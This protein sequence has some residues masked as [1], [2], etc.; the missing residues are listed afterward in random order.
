[1][2]EATITSETVPCG[3]HTMG[4][5][6]TERGWLTSYPCGGTCVVVSRTD[7]MVHYKC[8]SC[9]FHTARRSDGSPLRAWDGL[10]K[11]GT[12][13]EGSGVDEHDWRI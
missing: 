6:R 11:D 1:M 4:E 8:Q 10:L 13:Y 12:P 2:V 9:G 3:I 5:P 7:T